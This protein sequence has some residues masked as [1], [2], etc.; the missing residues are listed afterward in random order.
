MP[1]GALDHLA[2]Q[3]SVADRL[4]IVGL[5]LVSVVGALALGAVIYFLYE[6]LEDA[7]LLL[8]GASPLLVL[9]GDV[10]FW[11]ATG[12]AKI[13]LWLADDLGLGIFTFFLYGFLAL[14][15]LALVLGG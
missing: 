7:V 14:G 1:I 12:Q 4:G 10:V 13:Y 11:I 8:V 5:V 3:Q 6:Y 2:A 15:G 9:G